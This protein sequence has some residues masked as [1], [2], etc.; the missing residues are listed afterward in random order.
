[1]KF[2]YVII[3]GGNVAGYAAKEFVA[4]GGAKGEL[5]II[6]SEKASERHCLCGILR[7]GRR[8]AAT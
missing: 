7:R 5:C 4:N 1:M 2:R 6:S 3:G 8:I